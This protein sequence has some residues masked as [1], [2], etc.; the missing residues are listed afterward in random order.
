MLAHRSSREAIE[1]VADALSADVD[2]RLLCGVHGCHDNLCRELVAA[3][4]GLRFGYDEGAELVDA[5][6]LHVDVGNK[7]VEHF[8]FSVAHVALKL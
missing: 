4:D 8:A 1:S 7:S 5:D 3:Y 2:F 6:V